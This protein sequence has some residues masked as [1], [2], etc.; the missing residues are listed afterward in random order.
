M[1]VQTIQCLT[2]CTVRVLGHDPITFFFPVV[3]S[4]FDWA[5]VLWP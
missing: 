3:L 5:G 4:L 2:E 1:D